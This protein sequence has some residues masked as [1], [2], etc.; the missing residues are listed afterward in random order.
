MRVQLSYLFLIGGSVLA[1]P[2]TSAPREIGRAMEPKDLA[3]RLL[4]RNALPVFDI[5]RPRGLDEQRLINAIRFHGG[6]AHTYIRDGP[7]HDWHRVQGYQGKDK[8]DIWR[9]DPPVHVPTIQRQVQ[10]VGRR[11]KHAVLGDPQ[12]PRKSQWVGLDKN[13]NL[14]FTYYDAKGDDTARSSKTWPLN[15]SMN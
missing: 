7:N 9:E 14:E 2:Q 6:N 4:R 13:R 3:S 8:H 1:L 12:P 5:N 15:K 11:I 10:N